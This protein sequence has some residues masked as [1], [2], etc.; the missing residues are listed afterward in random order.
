MSCFNNKISRVSEFYISSDDEDDLELGINRNDKNCEN[1]ENDL[2]GLKFIN[3]M[4]IYRSYTETCEK[5]NWN[6]RCGRCPDYALD[7]GDDFNQLHWPIGHDFINGHKDAPKRDEFDKRKKDE[8]KNE[9]DEEMNQLS[10][11]AMKGLFEDA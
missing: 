7:W 5:D 4:K 1:D 6:I 2:C 11:M 3:D 9:F 10:E 8:L